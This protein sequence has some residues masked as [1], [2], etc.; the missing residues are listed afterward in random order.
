MNEP[1]S[2]PLTR[3]SNT[4][5]S[6]SRCSGARLRASG[7][8]TFVLIATGACSSKTP[9]SG[10]TAPTGT[11]SQPTDTSQPDPSSPGNPSPGSP[12][13]PIP[14][15]G[16][17]SPV[18]PS[19]GAPSTTPPGS[20][21]NPTTPSPTNTSDADSE[22]E[23]SDEP[24][25]T[26]VNP[27]P[28]PPPPATAACG[29][30]EDRIRITEV[31]LGA[32]V[33]TNEDEAALRPLVLAPV[34]TGGSRL[35]WM[36]KDG[37]LHVT[38][39]DSN[40]EASGVESSTIDARDF[41]DLIADENGGVALLTRDANGAG[42]K[43][44]GA[45]T[46]LCGNVDTLPEQ[47][48][49][50]D[51][52]MV[53]FDG[54]GEVWATQ[55]TESSAEKPPYLTSP[56]AEGSLVYIWQAYAHHGRLATDGSRYAGYYGAAISVSQD[57]VQADT[58]QAQ[59][60]NIHQGDRMDVLSADGV[61]LTGE[62]EFGWGCSHSGYERLA[63]DPRAQ[64]W[65]S[66]CKTDNDNRL[67]LAPNYATITPVD[68][69]ANNI[70]DVVLH[71]DE[72]YWLASSDAST[73]GD[74]LADV[75]LLHFSASGN[76]ATLNDTIAVAQDAARNERAPYLATYGTDGLL[77]GWESSGASNDLRA[78]DNERTF[79]LQ[80]RDAATG[81]AV[82]D[83]LEV[84]IIGNRYQSFRSFPDGSVGFPIKGTTATSVRILRVLPCAN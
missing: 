40:D 4:L 32:E 3:A 45:L 34:A 26:N 79:H 54:S 8:A 65:I 15:P 47:Y 33:D 52:Y 31:E 12:T 39:L 71:P 83:A 25:T 67:A 72:G 50:W 61:R 55:L 29:L 63:W 22:A 56:I 28:N 21:P 35:G 78:N 11:T 13:L 18:T 41:S 6:I 68:L 9:S 74:G 49:C 42:E 37:K 84:D 69:A 7:M 73:S 38:P 70:S 36:G 20:N 17:P 58:S 19:T 5:A 23:S 76:Q 57:C 75:S 30:S 24:T 64:R 62:G 77:V 10:D 2:R 44:C 66:V 53:R 51:M 43:H 81:A 82:G 1:P 80:V 59:G 16:N 60:V 48:A 46:N 14:T 27:T